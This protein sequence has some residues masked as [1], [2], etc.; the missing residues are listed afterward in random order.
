[1]KNLLYPL[2]GFTILYVAY[3]Q[4]SI[5]NV[6]YRQHADRGKT[7]QPKG[8]FNLMINPLQSRMLWSREMLDFNYF[9]F[10]GLGVGGTMVVR[11]LLKG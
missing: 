7:F 1:M 11:S 3:V 8:L 6:W 5:G 10:T 4:K 9:V 2:I